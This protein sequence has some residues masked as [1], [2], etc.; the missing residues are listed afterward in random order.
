MKKW[1]MHLSLLLVL[2]LAVF[3]LAPACAEA[4]TAGID[5][6]VERLA[7]AWQSGELKECVLSLLRELD[8]VELNALLQQLRQVDWEKE[9]GDLFQQL[10]QLDV[11]ALLAELTEVLANLDW[12]ALG[13]E[14][15]MLL[16]Q[17]LSGMQAGA[18]QALAA[19]AGDLAQAAA[20]L[21]NL[22]IDQALADLEEGLTQALD[23]ATRWLDEIELEQAGEAVFDFLE[24]LGL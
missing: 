12:E 14:A 19:I 8:Q 24:A 17:V 6:Y 9:L 22:T 2:C 1:M 7:D 16:G 3:A 13:E 11:E 10:S 20:Y 5:R 15:C 23:D 21:E 18:E 4:E